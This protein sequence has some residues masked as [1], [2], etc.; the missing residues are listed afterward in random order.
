MSKSRGFYSNRWLSFISHLARRVLN[1]IFFGWEGWRGE[2]GA[3][4]GIHTL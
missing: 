1:W 2:G 3:V 4:F